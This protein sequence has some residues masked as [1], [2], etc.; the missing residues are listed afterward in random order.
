MTKD[1]MR[2]DDLVIDKI[3]QPA[4]DLIYENLEADCYQVARICIDISA[5]FWILS[6]VKGA[7]TVAKIGDMGTEVY[8]YALIVAG[9]AAFMFLRSVFDRSP[10]SGRKARSGQGNPLRGPMSLHRFIF[11]AG[12]I[13]QVFQT[14]VVAAD[15]GS[16]AMLAMKMFSA[17]ALYAG[18]CS[19]RPPKRTRSCPGNWAA[20]FVG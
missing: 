20:D 14:M 13:V 3:C 9:L 16:V 15:F 19:N 8:Q 4:V 5:L 11:L 1:L 17:A 12:F 18:A 10:G 6:Q 2:L 7:I